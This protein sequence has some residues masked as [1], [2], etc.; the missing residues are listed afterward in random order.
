[1]YLKGIKLLELDRKSQIIKTAVKRFARH[2][3][4]KTT[5]EEIAGDL[6]IGKATIYNY[7]TS[8][9]ELF[10]EA[11]IWDSNLILEDIKFILNNTK[12]SFENNFVQYINYKTTV[13]E[14]YK[15]IYDLIILLFQDST[16]EKER[17]I[18]KNMLNEEEKIVQSSLTNEL[19]KRKKTTGIKSVRNIVLTS[20][21]LIYSN[22]LNMIK[23]EGKE[24][25]LDD[26]ALLMFNN[27]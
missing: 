3:L 10:Y 8:K 14:K 9:E 6:R 25:K 16:H 24:L 1:M 13:L 18:L 26:I 21:G 7:F 23:D 11:L 27:L 17:E 19:K 20:W 22:Q 5:L 4:G 12:Q 15:L 2:G